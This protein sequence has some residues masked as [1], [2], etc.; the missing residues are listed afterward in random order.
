MKNENS[1]NN[2]KIMKNEKNTGFVI[3]FVIA[4]SAIILLQF[5]LPETKVNKERKNYQL[6]NKHDQE[7]TNY[8][9]SEMVKILDKYKSYGYS[10]ASQSAKKASGIRNCVSLVLHAAYD[11]VR[12]GSTA[13]DKLTKLVSPP[14]ERAFYGINDDF[15]QLLNTVAEKYKNSIY[16]LT[17]GKGNR[18]P[19][20]NY[21]KALS[22]FEDRGVFVAQSLQK[23]SIRSD[24]ICISLPF[25]IWFARSI[26]TRI[27]YRAFGGVIVKVAAS[28]A[29]TI[30]D[31]PLPVG[32]MFALGFL[33]WSCYDIYSARGKF[34]IDLKNELHN[35]VDAYIF[36]VN[37]D[38]LKKFNKL[39]SNVRKTE[40][41]IA[42][43]LNRS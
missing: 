23:L 37:Q 32:D 19:E 22:G 18:L 16:D 35:S 17:D 5:Q 42:Q 31:G 36:K 13:E 9:N 12:G 41:K 39:K 26:L 40:S 29:L 43:Y 4:V 34:E 33:G 38:M 28:I 20:I 14:V 21:K 25:D 2:E 15:N 6:Y 24:I 7:I 27:I 11:K 3:L 1:E 10:A 8:F 30:A